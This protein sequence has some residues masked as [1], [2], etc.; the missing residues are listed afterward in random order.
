MAFER[1]VASTRPGSVATLTDAERV[2]F[3]RR[4]YAH[5]AGAIFGFVGLE[6]L[7]MTSPLGMTSP[8]QG[9]HSPAWHSF[10]PARHA[11]TPSVPAGPA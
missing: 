11:P 3:I 2:S 7:L 6:Y 8:W 10:V 9:V 4:T 5:L 1:S